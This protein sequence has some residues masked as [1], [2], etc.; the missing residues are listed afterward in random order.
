MHQRAVS[1]H[2]IFQHK[3]LQK[4][5]LCFRNSDYILLGIVRDFLKHSAVSDIMNMWTGVVYATT[6]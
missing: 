6:N 4:H 3:A 5:S 1:S 2:Q